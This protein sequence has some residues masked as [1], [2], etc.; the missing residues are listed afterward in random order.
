MST[1]EL[2]QRLGVLEDLRTRDILGYLLLGDTLFSD[3]T[4]EGI[5]RRLD[6]RMEEG[7]LTL[8]EATEL[9]EALGG[10]RPSRIMEHLGYAIEWRGINPDMAEV[11]RRK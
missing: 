8:A 2:A 10:T 11:R 9:V 7:A 6:E 4:L 1:A 5:G 3:S